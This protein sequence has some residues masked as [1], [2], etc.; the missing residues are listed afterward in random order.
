MMAPNA[1]AEPLTP[2]WADH[3][4]VGA[5][6]L[7]VTASV[8]LTV[9]VLPAASLELAVMLNAKFAAF[10]GI[11]ERFE[12]FQL[13][14]STCWLP[15]AATKDWVPSLSLAPTGMF[16]I[17]IEVMLAPEDASW[18]DADTPRL[19]AVVSTP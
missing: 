5:S 3:C 11:M 10:G 8:V 18:T 13:C 16:P 4:T 1:I 9:L 7:T 17:R 19:I 15:N 12:R 6:G 2:V 14:T